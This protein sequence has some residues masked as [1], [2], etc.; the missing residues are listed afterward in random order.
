[1]YST[2]NDKKSVVAKKNLRTVKNKIYKHM[3]SIY[4]HMTSTLVSQPCGSVILME[5]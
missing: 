4:K 2:D 3:T 5:L 1:M